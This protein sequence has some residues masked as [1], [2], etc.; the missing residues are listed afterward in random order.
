MSNRIVTLLPIFTLC[1]TL[2]LFI[3]KTVLLYW[4]KAYELEL[5]ELSF[6]VST[7]LCNVRIIAWRLLDV[8]PLVFNC[9]IVVIF[10]YNH[11]VKV[12]C[13]LLFTC[14]CHWQRKCLEPRSSQ[15]SPRT[16]WAP[17]HCCWKP[18]SRPSST[19]LSTW[20]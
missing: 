1:G 16:M 9:Y 8:I 6:T 12:V 2:C 13:S 17:H 11:P 14:S 10:Q 4:I 7:K 15:Q 19:D 3:K 5:F 20:W 18:T